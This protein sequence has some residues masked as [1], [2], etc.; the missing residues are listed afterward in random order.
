ML[1]L[2]IIWLLGKTSG[3]DLLSSNLLKLTEAEQT[4]PFENIDEY[5]VLPLSLL[6]YFSASVKVLLDQTL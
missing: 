4:F 2:V 5:P 1:I 6:R 3:T